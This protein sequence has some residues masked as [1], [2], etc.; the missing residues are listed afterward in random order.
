VL[1]KR[2]TRNPIKI[3]PNGAT[4][5]STHLAEIDLPMLPPAT[6]KAHIVPALD[7]CSL[8]LLGQLCDVG[9]NILLEANTLSVLDAGEA[10][11]TGSRD[12]STG[13]WHITLPSAGTLQMSHHV[14]KPSTADLA[15]FA[16][17][18]LFSPL[19]S[20]LEKALNNGYLT[21]FP[22]LNAQS[23]QKFPPASVPIAKGHL[24]QTPKNQRS[25]RQGTHIASDRDDPINGTNAFTPPDN[26]TK[27]FEC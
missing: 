21:N 26:T 4:M 13:M 6:H 17:A 24:D 5:E 27:M 15:A 7:N 2:L 16:Q 3:I 25:T 9:Y 19:L 14:G 20:T 1:K 18:T 23:L 11:L 22:G 10:I 12:H 8:L